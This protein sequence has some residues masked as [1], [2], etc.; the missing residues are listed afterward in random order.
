MMGLDEA[1]PYQ[2]PSPTPG[3][4]SVVI[5]NNAFVVR[6]LQ[7]QGNGS[8]LA[9]F[10]L[11]S[12]IDLIGYFNGHSAV[13]MTYSIS[14]RT[15]LVTT[16]TYDGPHF[17]I[18]RNG[19][20]G[21]GY[22]VVT[23]RYT[24]AS[25][26]AYVLPFVIRLTGLTATNYINTDV[27]SGSTYY[28][29]VSAVGADGTEG[30]RSSEVSATP[31]ARFKI[32]GLNNGDVLSDYATVSVSVADRSIQYGDLVLSI[33]NNVVTSTDVQ[34][35]AQGLPTANFSFYTNDFANGTHT[36][37]ISDALGHSDSR[38]VSFSNDIQNIAYSDVFDVS[39][40]ATD[41]PRSAHITATL[42]SA[43]PW[44]ATILDS[45]GNTVMTYNGT[46][47]AVDVTWNGTNAAANV[48]PDDTY[49]VVLKANASSK[50]TTRSVVK[51]SIGDT[52]ILIDFNAVNGGYPAAKS[53]GKFIVGELSPK[54]GTDFNNPVHAFII[55]GFKTAN[56]ALRNRINNKLGTSLNLLYVDAHGGDQPN[57]F[58]GLGFYTWY[59]Y[60]PGIRG[61]G[62]SGSYNV[63][64]IVQNLSYGYNNTPP[65]FV[66]IDTCDSDGSDEHLGLPT[67]M[68]G[69]VTPDF[70]WATTFGIDI[71]EANGYSQGVYLGWGGADEEYNGPADWTAWRRNLWDFLFAGGN[72]FQTAFDR[73][74]SI[75]Q[76]NE[77]PNPKYSG[78]WTGVGITTF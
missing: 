47:S 52:F 41:V 30:P 9:P 15:D 5:G 16:R 13:G 71:A 3:D 78:S 50:T 66:W 60:D 56:A 46:G 35:N 67:D 34:P 39:P 29:Q 58:F 74:N 17:D 76:F 69:N 25:G 33:D 27:T 4:Y 26:Q 64:A 18:T 31:V 54:V 62:R 12:T 21:L 37:F 57:P 28:Y 42:A 70:S 61:H 51:D 14:G 38:T 40:G 68:A 1:T 20:S 23:C 6:G 65:S 72:N 2:A 49:D 8:I 53:Y 75:T 44:T 55:D 32:T 36:I 45:N 73:D 7:G 59:S 77:I 10:N 19:S 24:D 43:Q 48:V 11:Y 22:V 63:R